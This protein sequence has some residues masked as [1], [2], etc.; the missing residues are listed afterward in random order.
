[1]TEPNRSTVARPLADEHAPY[2]AKYIELVTEDALV[3]LLE[4]ASSTPALLERASETQA[5]FRYAPGKWSVKQVVAHLIDCERVFSYRA[6]RI[7]RGDATPLPGFDEN[8]W[9]EASGAD[10][11][12]LADLVH[13]FRLVRAAT[14]AL[15]ATFDDAAFARRGQANGH[16]MSVRA[17]AYVIAGHE[18]AHAIMLRERYGL[19]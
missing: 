15:F 8:A 18:R 13:E 17:L 9:A 3:A 2:Y 6:L 10:A 19:A 14:L 4:Q 16:P 11:R 12:T 1:M 7:A 5:A